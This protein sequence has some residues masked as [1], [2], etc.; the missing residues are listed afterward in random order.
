V[1]TFVI[2][3]WT[4]LRREDDSVQQRLRGVAEHISSGDHE[5]FRD[6]SELLAFLAGRL[7]AHPEEEGE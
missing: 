6:S 7:G 4:P 2:R 1:E 3:V 5:S